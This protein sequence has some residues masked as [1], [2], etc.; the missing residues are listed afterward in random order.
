MSISHINSRLDIDGTIVGINDSTRAFFPFVYHKNDV[1]YDIKPISDLNTTLTTN[2]I[3]ISDSTLVLPVSIDSSVQPFTLS[4]TFALEDISIPNE[5]SKIELNNLGKI[6][7]YD[8][9][10]IGTSDIRY[11]WDFS[12]HDT[13]NVA[14]SLI[15]P[16]PFVTGT[17]NTI[18]ITW[19]LNKIVFYR[20]GVYWAECLKQSNC[21]IGLID[22][23]TLNNLYGCFK[24]IVIWNRV[25]LIE[26]IRDLNRSPL[27]FDPEEGV[28]T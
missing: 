3:V 13:N 19:D 28:C 11:V 15:D 14:M 22:V 18:T 12:I 20:N 21:V 25:L 10:D 17:Y 8:P 2:G 5:N 7:M 1:I 4:Y 6:W 9:L 23:V 16:I 26:E 27:S 24:N